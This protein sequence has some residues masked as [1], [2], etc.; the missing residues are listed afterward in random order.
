M[1]LALMHPLVFLATLAQTPVPQGAPSSPV[2]PRPAPAP[3]DPAAALAAQ[4][5]AMSL[6]SGMDGTWRG[7]AWTLSPTGEKHTLVQTE[8]VG[9]MLEG[10]VKVIEG[11]GYDAT[12]KLVFNA[13]GTIA[14]HPANK[15]YAMI[16]HAMGRSGQYVLKPTPEG[17]IWEIPAGPVVL[18]YTAT[19]KDGTW[20]E[21]GDRMVP[22][23][24]PVRFFE[25]ELRRVGGTDWPSAGAVGPK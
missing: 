16:S 8:R 10:A 21:V 9:P 6:L 11:R 17:F 5:T 24:E 2:V 19:L 15:A 3:Y 12:G 25:M 13:F 22:G 20:K 23:Q 14:Y 4:K 1:I 7:T 18:R